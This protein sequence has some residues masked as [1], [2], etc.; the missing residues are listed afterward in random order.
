[1]KT[2]HALSAILIFAL[3]ALVPACKKAPDI[4]APILSQ[5]VPAL[6]SP[7]ELVYLIGEWLQLTVAVEIGNDQEAA[8]LSLRE[9]AVLI[10]KGC[11]S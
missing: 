9:L 11:F 7:G 4:T 5:A 1:M 2:S 8:V 10:R 3:F 6:A